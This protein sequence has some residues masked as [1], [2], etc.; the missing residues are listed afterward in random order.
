MCIHICNLVSWE[1]VA[2]ILA[3]FDLHVHGCNG[4]LFKPAQGIGTSLV[5]LTGMDL[6]VLCGGLLR[7]SSLQKP[8]TVAVP[9]S[10]T[11]NSELHNVLMDQ[12]LY[13]A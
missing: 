2:Q 4:L 3:M 7:Q 5:L 6:L 9:S 11:S 1:I 8:S 13:P 12:T 10:D